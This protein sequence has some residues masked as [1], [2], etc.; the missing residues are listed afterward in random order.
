MNSE[1]NNTWILT[2]IQDPESHELMIELPPDLL[3]SVDC[4]IG[5]TL[6]WELSEENCAILTKVNSRDESTSCK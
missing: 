3:E 1:K 2:V 5:N 4:E 6:N